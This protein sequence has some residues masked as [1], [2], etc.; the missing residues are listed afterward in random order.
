MATCGDAFWSEKIYVACVL[1]IEN[2]SSFEWKK[3][4]KILKIW[5]IFS[6]IKKEKKIHFSVAF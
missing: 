6:Q 3:N 4:D 2:A 1:I 5:S